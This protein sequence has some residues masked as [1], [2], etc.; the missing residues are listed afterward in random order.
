MKKLIVALLLI[1]I[2]ETFS[3][4]PVIQQIINSVNQ[5]SLIYFVRELSGNIPTTINDTLQSILSRNK[6]QPGNALAETYIKQKLQSYN[7]TTTIQSFSTTCKNVIAIQTGNQFPN[8][9]FIICAHFDDMPNGATAPGADD[10]ASGTAAVIEAARIFS[11]Y[12]FPFTLV[13]ALWDEEE[14]G[15][16]GSN[17]FAAQAATNGDSILGVLN[18]D[19]IS[20][21]SDSNNVAEIHTNNTTSSL[22]LATKITEVNTDYNI[23]VTLNIKNPGTSAS[24]H[25]PFW[26]KGYG[27]VLLIEAYF[28]GDFNSYYHT[29]SDLIQNFNLPYYLKLTKLSIGTFADLGGADLTGVENN[30]ESITDYRLEQ[31]YPNPFNP[32]TTIKYTIPNVTLSGVEESRVILKVYDV[33][34]TEVA[35]LVN[36]EKP[37]G[38]YNVSFNASSLSS[39]I[40]FYKLHAGSFVDTKKMVLLK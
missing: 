3:Q 29:T 21:D 30:S 2:T 14:Q 18:L 15:L 37:A 5:D 31:N 22:Y 19:M 38:N 4:S 28:G 6:N 20:W 1:S 8:K 27:A 40:Y 12:S 13:Y 39:G 10:N 32:V 26:S 23:G 11:N 25:S 16:V 17:Y 9:K 34:G 7:L 33:L 24:D 35:N 36:E